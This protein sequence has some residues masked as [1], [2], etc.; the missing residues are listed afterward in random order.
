MGIFDL[1]RKTKGGA[2]SPSNEDERAFLV[3]CAADL[4]SGP[5]P[6]FPLLMPESWSRAPTQLCRPLVRGI[7]LPQIP[8]VALTYLIPAPGSPTPQRGFIRKERVD[9]LGKTV[10]DFEREALHNIRVRSASW[11]R[12]DLG[13][14]MVV[15]AT[16]DYLAAERILD[17]EFLQQAGEMVK[18]KSLLVGI[19]ARGQ[20]YATSLSRAL[21][22]P[23]QAIAFKM[24]IEKMFHEAGEIGITPWPFI[25]EDGRVNTVAEL[26]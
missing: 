21:A 17:S 2:P 18:D 8:V 4:G 22:S 9:Q 11:S 26:A 15:G 20:L 24:I 14:F 19:P 3:T 12:I 16:D 10:A 13:G 25:A 7:S 6:V 5:L 23:E 1:F